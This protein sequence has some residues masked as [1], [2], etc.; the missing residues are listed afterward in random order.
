MVDGVQGTCLDQARLS[1]WVIWRPG[2]QQ[3]VEPV[4]VGRKLRR[5]CSA[6]LAHPGS[7]SRAPGS[8][9]ADGAHALLGQEH[10]TTETVRGPVR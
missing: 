8:A 1:L 5:S 2:P 3:L 7:A 10:A 9:D 4:L 6:S